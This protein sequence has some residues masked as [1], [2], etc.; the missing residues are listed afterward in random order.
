MWGMIASAP[1]NNV[2]SWVLCFQRN[3]QQDRNKVIAQRSWRALETAEGC[4]PKLVFVNLM[5]VHKLDPGRFV[6]QELTMVFLLEWMAP[7]VALNNSHVSLKFGLDS[8]PWMHGPLESFCKYVNNVIAA[9]LCNNRPWQMGQHH[10][11]KYHSNRAKKPAEFQA[12]QN[13]PPMLYIHM[14][15]PTT[16]AMSWFK[17]L[18]RIHE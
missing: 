10:M 2:C 16:C 3:G 6:Q 9:I 12:T 15:V 7:L 8:S 14:P 18:E 1:V 13:W 5:R 4:F 17:C 11:F